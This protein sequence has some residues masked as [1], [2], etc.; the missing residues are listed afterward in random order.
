MKQEYSHVENENVTDK[1]GIKLKGGDF[2]GI[3]YIYGSVT[4]SEDDPRVLTFEFE[5]LSNPNNKVYEDSEE[6]ESV[7]GDILIQEIDKHMS[8][9]DRRNDNKESDNE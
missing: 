1:I 3:I 5:V 7:M 9:N 4:F 8:D 2:D 6:F